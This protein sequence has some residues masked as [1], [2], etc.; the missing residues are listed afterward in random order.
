LVTVPAKSLT[1]DTAGYC[2]C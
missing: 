2:S 1:K